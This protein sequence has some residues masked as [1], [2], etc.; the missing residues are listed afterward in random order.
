ME[1]NIHL[2]CQAEENIDF[3]DDGSNSFATGLPSGT[4]NHKKYIKFSKTI[5]KKISPEVRSLSPEYKKIFETSVFLCGE[6]KS[7]DFSVG[8]KGGRK[9]LQV[10]QHSKR[11]EIIPPFL[12]LSKEKVTRKEN[13]LCKLPN[14]YSLH[15]TSSPLCTSSSI[16][17]EKEMLSNL[18]MTLYDEVTHGYLYSQE[19]SALH[20]ACKIFSKIRSGKIYVND[21]PVILGILR[22]S[23]SDLEMRQALKTIDIDVNGM[24]DF[25][26]FLKAVADVS[27][28]VSQNP[29]FWDALKIFCR[30]KGGRV[31]TD[32]IFGVLDSM[33]VPINPEI[34]EEVIKHTY[35]DSNHMVDIGDIIFILNELQEQYEDV[36]IT[37]ES[38]LDEITSDRKLSSI[39]GCYLKYK[40][41]NSLSSKLPEPSI[42]K[43]LNNK[44]NQ[45]YSKIMENDDL[46]SKRSKNTWQIRKFLDGVSSSNVGVQEPYSK[47]GINFKKHSEKG[48]IHDS[49]SKPQSLKSSTSLSKS[50]DKS[51]ISSIPKLQKPTVRKRSSLLKQV[52]STEK[53]AINTLENFC[54]AISK[55]QENYISAEGLQSILPSVG[56][57]LLDKEFQ[58]IVTDTSRNENGMVELDDFISTLANEQ[59]FPECNALPGVIKAIDKI[60]DKNVDYEDLNTCL[61]DFGIYLS[62]PEF[63]KIT[64]LTEAGETKKVNFKEFIDTMMS[65]TECFSEKLLLPDSI[66]TL[67]NLRKETMSVSDLWNILSSLNSNL[68]KD[69]FLAALKL[70]TVDEGDKVQFEE[71]AQ[72]VRNMRDAAR[73]EELQEVVLAADL[74]EGDMIAEENLEDFLRNIGIKSPKE[75]VEKIL[76]S[77]F[78]SED[79][80]VNIKDCMRALSDT[81]KFSNYIALNETINTLDSMKE[82]CQ[83]DKDKNLDVLENTDRL[84]FTDDILQEV[85]DDSF[86]EDFRKEAS[87]L[88]LPKVNEIKEV[89]NILS[90]V[91]NGKIGVPDLEHALKCLNVNLTEEDFNGALNC[92]NV[93]DNMEVDLKDFLIKMKESPHFQ[94]SKATQ[95]LLAATQILQNDLIDVSDLKTLLMDKD[96]HTANAILTVMLRHVPEH[97]SGKVTIQEFMTKF[98]DILTIP[99]P[100][101]DKFY[102]NNIHKNDVT[103]ISGLQ[104]NLNAMGIYLTDDKIQKTL[105]NTNPNDEVVHFKDFIRELANT[106]EFIECQKIEDA[107]NIINSVCDGKV[108]I[109]DLLSTLK[110][111]EKP[112]DE[113]QFKVLSNSATDG[114]ADIKNLKTVLDNMG[115][116]LTD[117]ELEDLT[118]SLPVGADNKV[119]LKALEDEVKAFTGKADIKNLKTVLDN[120]GIKLT[121]KELEDLTQS[122]PVGA[123]NK[124]AL[125]ALEDE[126]KAFTE[127]KV[128]LKDV[129]DV[130]TNSPKPSTPFNNLF[131][132]IKTLDSIR[133]D[134][135]PVNELSSKLL[136][137]GI[138]VSNKTFQEILRQA[139]VDENNN[140]SL[141]KILENLNTSKPISVFE[142]IDTA[143]STVSLMNCDRVQVSDLK[144]AFE[145]LNIS[146]KPEEHQMLVK[147]LDADEKGDTSLKSAILALKS[148]RRL[149]D[150][151]EVNKLA[152]ALDKVT[153]EKLDA[154]D[155]NSVLKGLGIYFPEEELQEVLGSICVD[156]EGKVNLKDCLSQ[157]MQTPYFTKA[158]K[159]EDSLKVLAS[160]KKNV[161]NPDDLDFMLKTVGVPLPQDVIQRAL[162]NVAPREDGTVN[163]QEFMSNLVNSGFSSLPETDNKVKKKKG[164]K[165]SAPIGGKIDVSNVD[166]ILK[167]MDIK[168]T[169]EEQQYLLDH[170]SA[171]ADEDMDMNTLTGV[172]KMLKE[173][174][175]ICNLDNFLKDMGIEVTYEEYTELVN[176]LP[177]SADGKVT[178][179]QLMDTIKT[180]KGDKVNAKKPNNIQEKLGVELT[181]KESWNLQE[182]LPVDEGKVAIDNLDTILEKMEMNFSDKEFE[183]LSHNWPADG[184]VKRIKLVRAAIPVTGETVDIRD[185]DNV[186]GNMGIELTK[187]ELGELT[188]NLPV[189]AK[190]ETDLKSLMDTVQVITGGEVDFNDLENVLQNMGIELTSREHLELEKL[191]PI[192]ANG[193]IYKNRLLNCVKGIKE[194]QVNVHDIDSI[195]GNMAFKL[196]AEELNDL[197]PNLP[198]NG[199][200]DI[201]NLKTVLDN[202]GIKLTDKELEDL[203]QSLP[204][205]ADNKVALKALEDEVKAFTGKVD[206]KNLKTVLDNMGIKLTDKELEDL[207]QSLPVGA[208]NKVALKALEDEV[209]AFTGKVDIKNLKTVLD[210]MGIKLTDK[211]LE[212]LTQSLPVGADNKVALKAL[213]DEV[214]AFTGK[215]DIKN[216]KTVLDNMGIKL[217]DKELE[218]LTQSLPVGADNKVALKAL[219]D[220]VKAFTGKVDIKN[221]KTVLDNMGIKLT[222]KELEDLTQSLPVGADNKVALKALEDEVKAF[223]GEEV[224]VNDMKTI[225]GNM[226][227]ELTDKEL[228]ELVN[229][230][231]VDDGKVYQKR[232]LDGIKFLRGGKIDSSKVDMVLGNMGINLTEKELEDLTQNLPVDVNGKVDLKKVMN[233]MKYFTG[234]KVDT[235]KLKSVLGNLGIELMPDEHLNLLKTLPVNADGKVYQKRL[236]KGIKSL[237]QGS[238]DV[239]KLDTL[240]EN[241][242]IKITEEEFMD[243]TERL[244]D[245]SEKKVKLNK[246]IKE[247]SAVLGKQVDVCDLEDA[248][249]D[250]EI[251]VPYEDYLHL[252]KTLPLDAEGKV[253]QKRLLDGIKTVKRGKVDINDLDKFLE[254]MGIELSEKELEDFSK[255]LPVDVDQKVELKNMMLR[256]KDFTGE[257]VDARD[258]KNVLG[259]MGIEVNDKDCVELLKLLPVDGDKKVF[260]N[261]LLTGLKSFKGGKVDIGNLKTI[262]GNM[263]IKLKNKEL[264][265]VIQNQPVD[266][267][268]NVP[269]KKVMDD[270]KAIIGEKLNVENLKNILEGLGIEFT[271]KEYL[272]LV[273]NLQIDDDGTI[274][275]NR[276]LDGVKSFKG[277]RVDVSNLENVL[278]NVKIMLPD[279]ELKDLSQNLPVDASGMTDLHK[280]LKEVNKF[281][282]GKIQA[283]DIQKVLGDMGVE[284]TNRELWNLMKMLP[285]T[286]DG[287]VYKNIL[288]DNIKSFP[289]GKCNVS[290][291][292]TILENMGYE[293]EDEEIEYLQNHLPTTDEKKVKLNKVME[294]VESF[295]GTKINTNEVDD[296]L[297]NIGIELTPKERWKLLKTLPVTSDGKVCR[298][299][300]LDRLKTFQG[301]KVFENKLETILENMNYKLENE[302]MKDLRNH[303][304]I[305]D[306]GKILLNSVIRAANLF[307]GDKINA[308]DIQLYLGNVGIEFTNKE[309][310]DLLDIVPLDDNKRV[311]KDRLMDGVKTYRGG[312]VNVNKIDD[313]LENMRIPLEEEEIEKLC[314]DLPLDDERRVK[315]DLLLN[316]VDE[317]LGEEIDYQDLENILKNIGLRLQ[318]K[319]NSV[320]MKSLPL[321][322]AGKLYKHK[323]L[324]GIRSLKGVKLSVD[325]LEPFMEH[326]GFEL[327]EEE[328]QDL[329]NNLPIDDEGRVNVNV[330]MDEGYLFT[331]EK[332][333]ARNLENFLENMGINLTEDKGMQLLNNLPIDAKGKVYVNRLMKELRGLEGTKVSSDKMEIFMKSMGI[334]LKEKEIQALKDHLPVDDN[335]K[336]D[337]N[338][339]MDEV[340]NVTGEKI[341]AGDVKNVLENMG[342][343]I[344]NKE[345][346]KLLKTLPVSADKKVFKK[347]LLDGVKSFRGGQVNVND[348]TS[349]LQN[350]GFRLEEKEIKDLKSHLPV[351]ENEKVDLDVL[352]DAAKAFTGEKVEADNLKNVLRN[353][354]IELTEKEHSML[355]KTLPVCDGK[356]YKKKL[357]DSVKPFKGKKVSVSNLETLLNNMEIEVGKEEYEDLLNHLPVDENEMVDV[358]VVMDEAKAFTGE[359]VNVSNL[360]N[361]LR[362]MGL[363]LTD[364]EHKKL[365]KTLPI[366]TNGKV[367]KN[368]LLKGVKALNGPRV[369][370][371]KVETFLENMGT[372]IKDEELEELMTQLPTEGETAVDLNDLMDAVSYIKG[373]VIDVQNLDN[374]LVS[375][376]IEL[377]EEEMKE[378]MPHLKFNGNGKINVKSIMEGLKKFKPKGMATLHKL[379]TANDIKDRVTGHMAVSEIKPKFK[380]N[381]LTKVPISHSKRDRDLPGSLQ[382]QLQH[383]EKKLSASQ[384]AAFQDAYNFFN[385]DKTGCIDFHG[386]MCTVAKLGMNLTKHDVYNELK[387]ADIDRDGKVNFSDFIK[388]LT[389]KNLFLKAVVPEK[390]TCLDL[391][392]NP[393]ILLFEILSKLLETSALPKKSILEIVSYFQRKFQHTGPGMLWSPYTMGYGKRTLKPDICTPPSSSMAAFANAARIAIMKEKDLFKFLEELKRCNSHSDSPYSKIPI[394]PLFP[395]VDGVVMGKPFKDMQKLEMLRRKEPLNFF[396]DYFFHK[397]DW[398]TQAANIKSMDPASGYSNNITIDQILKKKQTCTV[399]DETA[400]KQHVKRATDTYNFGIALEHRKEMLNLWQ[401]IRGDLIGID[402]R[403]ESFYDT[404]STYTWSWNVCQELLSP[405]DLRLYDAYVNRN[406]SHNSRS[407][408]SSDT[409]ECDT[410]SG[411]KRKRKGLKGFQ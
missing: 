299:L 38:P 107:W 301:G 29:A 114:K 93:S 160:I 346:K 324:D 258:L 155:V 134:T 128:I 364:E 396:E 105:D 9:S 26:N 33:G 37:E 339:M 238:V 52:S 388:V 195:L 152:K 355:L 296:I 41:K 410:D 393:G 23:I 310:Q 407:F 15:K 137:A 68:K 390:E 309:N 399:A 375:E 270:V 73:L 217:T 204:V 298:N 381:P 335:G 241:M 193:K 316:E 16:T 282:G 148:N 94:K 376:G 315:L 113:E 90:H 383:K 263:G 1:T 178:Q 363:V 280:L 96:L 308:S 59:S 356:V 291:I 184:K 32:E 20:K 194:L 57:T 342:I 183:E 39:A 400:I 140:V 406:S 259:D 353:M 269:L 44:S 24:L 365:L 290:K 11:T 74:L 306:N 220:E 223:T 362:K 377:T 266:A 349:V 389:D 384:M 248:L 323:L 34:L 10:Q 42:S 91:D 208:D 75:E 251:E 13:S 159:T 146:L 84:S 278:E 78:V 354:G 45:Y 21:L 103:T 344:T 227:I 330:V 264:Q 79:N 273:Q 409:S 100:A 313:A 378:L 271:P 228:T 22:I 14:Q 336:T 312:K 359:K 176:H 262:L 347:E 153:N 187:E 95:I 92:C 80:M 191:L 49:K 7:S 214:K 143:L 202:M 70:V 380:L 200:V 351:T 149:Q 109:E 86:V 6:E 48:E 158:S 156:K 53:T 352:M 249:K 69:E 357:L 226:G 35:I 265:S 408:S 64:E 3:L 370:I 317:I 163:L 98:S 76:Q 295:T 207:T 247:L 337:L 283:K 122:L 307:S 319:E 147:T 4:I 371:K 368:R 284:L 210:N 162:K 61:Q 118:Q 212:D 83:F 123:D 237:E 85:M 387:C 294:N 233:E 136:S 326:M 345:H 166:A 154:D 77:D 253:Y 121:D 169:E 374:F 31:S 181:N 257:K 224:D 219:E 303:L 401:K 151:R 302:E 209:K 65:N 254:N 331:G 348:L 62:K 231:P 218:D 132:E 120:M 87:N 328:Y 139:S 82:N 240:L 43:K 236:M 135:M 97:E 320:L 272:E 131:R 192:D 205:G 287:K 338:T 327:E 127:R 373:E 215:V 126:V 63:K 119:A 230:L 391:A 173:K 232:L 58:K 144:N 88:K 211:E 288:L 397:R 104:K 130:F 196:T 321:D 343:E 360:G 382:C 189:D 116:K 366:C 255:D 395:N 245:D 225:L 30:I 234:D 297:K 292:G 244:P 8:K 403:N 55:L 385:K 243:L 179:L 289:G 333:D 108:D 5:E 50:L 110:S 133:N 300:L 404:F 71:F 394:F 405:K 199:K 117:K 19:L 277:G 142:D 111:L 261:R 250:M 185:L 81:Q 197:T 177:T 206:I 379:K 174:I 28:M 102:N 350:T 168:L 222:D 165:D 161:A 341:H 180:L 89:A 411:R 334:D 239:N 182:H 27:Y 281:T 279:K 66:E 106:D 275:E 47:N 252:V 213:E 172:V 276:L 188:R 167:N 235:N 402:S 198:V 274:S 36:P 369:K 305:D 40:K 332:V 268:G 285:I 25:S 67:D 246:L 361:E 242:G 386:L 186:L 51:D 129:I 398:K 318:L 340:K 201:K 322:A 124:V 314:E 311:Y 286:D 175:E 72:V 216:L 141:K 367:Y 17:R 112:L 304:K 267:N 115:I 125:K 358:N 2:F 293:L 229:N 392:G 329:K 46:E 170:L 203:T 171:T 56:I 60:K 99:K 372:K 190:G 325:K 145:D 18:Y 221:L 150:F 260:R 164:I 101:E 138:P 54:E 256:I 157:L 12:K